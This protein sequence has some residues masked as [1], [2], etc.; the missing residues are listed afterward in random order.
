MTASSPRL[1]LA[2]GRLRRT[3]SG[4]LNGLGYRI[5]RQQ[6]SVCDSPGLSRDCTS[7]LIVRKTSGSKTSVPKL[8]TLPNKSVRERRKRVSYKVKLME[9]KPTNVT[10][11]KSEAD[12]LWRE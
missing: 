5:A 11:V 12:F 8:W 1:S 9:S 6:R 2:R 3:E 4:F 7:R 10:L